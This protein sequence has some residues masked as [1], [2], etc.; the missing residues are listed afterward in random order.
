AL[1]KKEL[2]DLLP[3]TYLAEF[4]G[5]PED[6]PLFFVAYTQSASAYGYNNFDNNQR[7]KNSLKGETKEMMKSLLIHP[8]NVNVVIDQLKF[9]FGRPEQLIDSQLKKVKELVVCELARLQ[10][11]YTTSTNR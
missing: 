6:W 1:V 3:F 4:D 2:Q 8:D 10:I 5:K 7:I 9:C 11:T